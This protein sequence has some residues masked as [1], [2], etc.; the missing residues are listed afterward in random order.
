MSLIKN[1]TKLLNSYKN[2]AIQRAMEFDK[3]RIIN[4]FINIIEQ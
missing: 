2:I 1:S 4:D 3:D